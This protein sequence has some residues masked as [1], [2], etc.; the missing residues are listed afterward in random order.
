[1]RLINATTQ[2]LES[3]VGRAPP[4]AIL[5]HT[6]GPEE[7]TFNEMQ[8]QPDTTK[9][10]WRKILL[11]CQQAKDD[12]YSY[13]WCDTCCIDKSSSAELS[14]SINSMFRWYQEAEVCYAFLEDIQDVKEL[15]GARWFTRGWTL[16]ELIAPEW[17]VFY[18]AAWRDIGTRKDL[19]KEVSRII[20]IDEEFLAGANSLS[21]IRGASF[22]K[23]VS[24]AADRI[25]TRDEDIAYCLM[26]LF[27]VNMPLL[28]GEGGIKAFR[29]LQEE[30][31]KVNGD[32]SFLTW[33][34][35]RENGGPNTS[36]GNLLASHPKDFQQCNR[37]TLAG[38]DVA[39]FSLNNKGLRIHLPLFQNREVN[40]RSPEYFAVLACHLDGEIEHRIGIPLRAMEK[41]TETFTLLPRER[42]HSVSTDEFDAARLTD[43]FILRNPK[44]LTPRSLSVSDLPA[45]LVLWNPKIVYL[46]TSTSTW[47]YLSTPLKPGTP[48]IQMPGLR[49]EA[50]Y[51]ILFHP[52][53]SYSDIAS[54]DDEN[55]SCLRVLV[56]VDVGFDVRYS[57]NVRIQ[58]FQGARSEL[59]RKK[60][61]ALPSIPPAEIPS[62]SRSRI[63]S[64]PTGLSE[65]MN[66]SASWKRISSHEVVCLEIDL[67]VEDKHRAHTLYTR[68]ISSLKSLI[69]GD[70]LVHG[71]YASIA[72]LVLFAFGPSDLTPYEMVTLGVCFAAMY[73]HLG[74]MQSPGFVRPKNEMVYWNIL[75]VL[76]LLLLSRTGFD[77]YNDTHSTQYWLV[78]HWLS[79]SWTA[80]CLL[81][82]LADRTGYKSTHT[83]QPRAARE[84]DDKIGLES[85]LLDATS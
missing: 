43:C 18:N 25:T 41:S 69:T 36:D 51:G 75:L 72:M 13:V 76:C 56:R 11:A 30:F 74:R 42:H 46:D 34:L 48:L 27:D 53:S 54:T 38:D 49:E 17:L 37:I 12:G 28:Y 77:L 63:L 50:S 3:F 66:A 47:V 45:S 1:M 24:W 31:L 71:L 21:K 79:A 80:L 29:R 52:Q 39:P 26:G 14:E 22:A 10:G 19:A 6:W 78:A 32:Q 65:T 61:D 4:Y 35:R 84:L 2:E 23:R 8:S 33:R 58:L 67:T 9:A 83:E 5:S 57:V 7:V 62:N 55:T 81:W 16:Q 64:I 15:A 68:L 70:P 59:S 82:H 44:P 85:L 73:S 40:K 60:S 20:D